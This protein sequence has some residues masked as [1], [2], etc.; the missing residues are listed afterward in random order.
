MP[1]TLRELVQLPELHVRVAVDSSVTEPSA[2]DP[3]PT[4]ADAAGRD[5]LDTPVEWAYGSDLLDPTPWLEAGQLLLTNG[6]QFDGDLD[7]AVAA[8]YVD[9]LAG[10]DV[11]GLGFA[12]GVAHDEVPPTLVRAAAARGLVLLEVR[13][14]TPFIALI[15]AVADRIAAD[16]RARLE[17]SLQTQRDLARAALRPDGLAAVLRELERRLETWVSL[18]DGGGEPIDIAGVAPVPAALA[19]E[20]RD[21]V[22]RVLR[23]GKPAAGRVQLDGE[24]ATLQTVGRSGELRGVLVVGASA[25]LDAAEAD[26]VGNVVALASVALEQ[27]RTL[28]TARRRVR[29]AVLELLLAGVADAAEQTSRHVADRL[30][31]GPVR[32][33]VLA[34]GDTTVVEAFEADAA[35]AGGSVCFAAERAGEL[36][37]LAEAGAHDRVCAIVARTGTG[38]GASEPVERDADG[39]RAGIAEAR[40]AAARAAAGTVRT[41]AELAGDGLLGVLEHAGGAELGRRL[42][43][44]VLSSPS[45]DDRRLLHT[46]AVWIEHHGAWDPASRELGIHRHTLRNRLRRLEELLGIDLSRF[47]DRAQLWAAMRLADAGG[48][49]DA[50]SS[51]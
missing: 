17:W 48:A 15:R 14:R 25:P 1:I 20:V 30:P 42:L 9:R 16:R 27:Q 45:A 12:T 4:G 7:A 13:D 34:A 2:V 21:A 37:V 19:D 47:E 23:T 22:R 50:S 11:V 31:E 29:A 6:T 26:V 10:A 3:S 28:A 38:A 24:G 51:R 41:Y 46:A 44:P 36:V 18:Y 40:R 35:R 49:V 43:D 32:V 8:A 33:Y 5:P 39:L